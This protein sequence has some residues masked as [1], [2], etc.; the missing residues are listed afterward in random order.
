[1]KEAS[2]YKPADKPVDPQQ[3]TGQTIDVEARREQTKS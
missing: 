1:M 2:A 3:V